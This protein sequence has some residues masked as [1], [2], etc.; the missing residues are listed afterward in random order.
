MLATAVGEVIWFGIH[1]EFELTG[2]ANEHKVGYREGRGKFSDSFKGT[3]TEADV[4][5]E[6]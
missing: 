4:K 2:F 6:D 1:F 3:M 5:N